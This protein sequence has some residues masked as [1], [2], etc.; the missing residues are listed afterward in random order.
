MKL[1][2]KDLIL[3]LPFIDILAN[4][5]PFLRPIRLVYVILLFIY[6]LNNNGIPKQNGSIK[7]IFFF[8]FYLILLTLFNT[9][10][11]ATTLSSTLKTSLS[12]FYYYF[13]LSLV[14]YDFTFS[15]LSRLIKNGVIIILLILITANVFSI[16]E[17][18]YHSTSSFYFGNTG[19]NIVKYLAILLACFP[20]LFLKNDKRNR[21]LYVIYAIAIV[22]IILSTKR[23]ALLVVFISFFFFVKNIIV[24]TRNY[25]VLVLIAL[26]AVAMGYLLK[27][28]MQANFEARQEELKISENVEFEEEWRYVETMIVFERFRNSDILHKLIGNET[29]NEIDAYGQRYMFH[30]DFAVILG[31]TGL[32]GLFLYMSIFISLFLTY[33]KYMKC[34]NPIN[35][36]YTTQLIILLLI[37]GLLAIAGNTKFLG[38]SLAIIMY[39]FGANEALIIKNNNER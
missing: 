21:I 13:G 2:R 15:D 27:D 25:S 36:K 38:G 1:L 3:F 18:N 11:I 19:V 9:S 20:I 34:Y 5:I 39:L 8:S 16:G 10:S 29:F 17:I 37:F 22:L 14:K 6:L 30:N 7:L 4:E 28:D 35:K 31:S 23:S 26:I 33:R 32:I 24:K 12:L